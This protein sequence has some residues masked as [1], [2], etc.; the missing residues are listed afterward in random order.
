SNPSTS[1]FAL[2]NHPRLPLSGMKQA[3]DIMP[4]AF[5]L[6]ASFLQT[7][8]IRPK[9]HERILKTTILVLAVKVLLL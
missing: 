9:R 6:T 2:L 5:W 3:G 4:P 1:G 7:K 8:K